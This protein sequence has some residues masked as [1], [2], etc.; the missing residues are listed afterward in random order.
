VR[1]AGF[2]S[3]FGEYV[4]AEFTLKKD[5]GAGTS[6]GYSASATSGIEL[7]TTQH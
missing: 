7:A 2:F 1:L 4:A 3:L 6:I 5:D